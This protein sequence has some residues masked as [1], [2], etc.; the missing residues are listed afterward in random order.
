VLQGEGRYPDRKARARIDRVLAGIRSIVDTGDVA[1]IGHGHACRALAARWLGLP[2]AAGALFAL[3]SGAWSVLGFEHER[4]VLE[5]W[6][7]P[8]ASEATP[9]RL[10]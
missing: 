2:V 1:V 6:N 5:R 7:L 4:P 9:R 10:Y 3:D 8:G